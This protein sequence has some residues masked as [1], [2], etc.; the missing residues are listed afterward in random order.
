MNMIN[1]SHQIN[2]DTTINPHERNIE[3]TNN[4]ALINATNDNILVNE[5][6]DTINKFELNI[7]TKSESL[8]SNTIQTSNKSNQFDFLDVKK[9]MSIVISIGTNP[10]KSTS[11]AKNKA[12]LKLGVLDLNQFNRNLT[13]QK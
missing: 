10:L 7:D 9:V 12:K 2:N 5:Y 6:S 11:L 1:L 8:I 3:S 4:T 13:L